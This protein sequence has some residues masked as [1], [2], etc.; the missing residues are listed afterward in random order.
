MSQDHQ[1]PLHYAAFY[2]H[3]EVVQA[4]VEHGVPLD[5]PD[6]F[7][8]LVHCSAALNGHLDVVRYLLEECENP[9]DMNAIDE[10]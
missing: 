1:T 8:R 4:L 9:I 3:L 10:V 7:G 6:K 2:G 5:I